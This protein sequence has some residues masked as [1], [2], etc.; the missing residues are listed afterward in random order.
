MFVPAITQIFV[1]VIFKGL[2]FDYLEV[3]EL[4]NKIFHIENESDEAELEDK[5]VQLGYESAFMPVN[6]GTLIIFMFA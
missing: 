4:I 3:E 2:T 5:F 6:W 1:N